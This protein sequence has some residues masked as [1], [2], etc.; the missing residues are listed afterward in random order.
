MTNQE[1]IE[2]GTKGD[3]R[4]NHDGTGSGRR[5]TQRDKPGDHDGHGFN[6]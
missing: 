3:K 4:G 1:P 6:I 2:G 5:E